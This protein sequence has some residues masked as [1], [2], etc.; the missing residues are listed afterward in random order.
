MRIVA[1]RQP[2]KSMKTITYPLLSIVLSCLLLLQIVSCG[3]GSSNDLLSYEI[4]TL[5]DELESD[6]D[7]LDI[8]V[9]LALLYSDAG[10]YKK[11]E[12]E[13]KAVLEL[14]ENYTDALFAL[15]FV[16]IE[17]KEY[18]KA[19]EPFNKIVELN[20]DNPMRFINSQLEA[21]YYYLG[22][23]YREL[24]RYQDAIDAVNE[25]LLINKTDADAWYLLGE[26]YR[27]HEDYAPAIDSYKQALRFVPEFK[28]VYRGLAVCY[29]KSGENELRAYALAM[30]DYCSGLTDSAIRQLEEIDTTDREFAEIYLG[31][32]MAYEKTGEY[33]NALAAY[34]QA[35][36]IQPD[37]WLAEMKIQALSSK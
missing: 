16:Y 18:S 3:N 1:S 27:D 34:E 11:A 23:A 35:L 7:N 36:Q 13:L 31:L 28:E 2:G 4:Q 20:A 32:G 21:A 22:T 15:G 17:T 24:G 30:V 10:Q 33:E 9:N 29:E 8:R 5:K 37:M 19:I 25:A 12:T 14:E 26:A 6:P